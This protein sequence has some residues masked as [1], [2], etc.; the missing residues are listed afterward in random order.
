MKFFKFVNRKFHK[1]NLNGENIDINY[2]VPMS[3]LKRIRHT[4]G[5]DDDGNCYYDVLLSFD[6]IEEEVLTILDS[7]EELETYLNFCYEG[8]SGVL[9]LGIIQL[10]DD[11]DSSFSD[12]YG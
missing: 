10:Y 2:V 3:S 11:Y 1:G 5:V 4:K 6:G 9:D 8:D 7:K 12:Y